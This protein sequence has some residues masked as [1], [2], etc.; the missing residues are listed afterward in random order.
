MKKLPMT[1]YIVS[2]VLVSVFVIKSIVDYTQYAADINSAP[3]SVWVLMNALYFIVPAIIVLFAG[4]I[5]KKK[6]KA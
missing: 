5:V 6:Q 2:T 3:F 1:C 4:F